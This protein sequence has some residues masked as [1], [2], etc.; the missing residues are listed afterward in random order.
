MPIDPI[1]RR[2]ADII[3]VPSE[4]FFRPALYR[5]P[6]EVM[7][8]GLV[9]S[10][11][12]LIPH[13]IKSARLIP[14]LSISS[15]SGFSI[16]TWVFWAFLTRFGRDLATVIPS[17]FY[18]GIHWHQENVSAILALVS[19]KPPKFS[20]HLST[21][22]RYVFGVTLF[23]FHERLF[24]YLFDIKPFLFCLEVFRGT[25][26]GILIYLVYLGDYEWYTVYH[27]FF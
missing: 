18:R 12:S 26:F 21:H 10:R 24:V 7:F 27:S 3:S 13:R 5:N 1:S 9:F 19:L 15:S 23:A 14:D 17:L 4:I 25:N 6:I 20:C 22:L 8:L 16:R 2:Q 11:Y